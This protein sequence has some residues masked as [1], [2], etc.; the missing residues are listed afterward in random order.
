M[1]DIPIERKRRGLPWVWLILAVL[2]LALVIWLFVHQSQSEVSAKRSVTSD[3]AADPQGALTS[4]EQ[5]EPI[6][7]L[8]ALIDAPAERVVGRTVRLSNVPA[9]AI[10][11]DAGFWV[12]GEKGAREYVILHEVR[13]PNTPMEG[14]IDVKEGDRLDIAGVVRSADEGV[15]ADAA[16]PGPTAPLPAGVTHYIDASEVTKTR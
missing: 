16:I 11:A 7:D 14:K 1:V 8:A 3:A 13:T 4:A 12:T 5:G 10:A 6:T 2:I 15:P 9:G